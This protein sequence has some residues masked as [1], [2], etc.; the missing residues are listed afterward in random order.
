MKLSHGEIETFNQTYDHRSVMHY[1]ENSFSSD[2]GLKTIIPRQENKHE[3]PA[4]GYNNKISLGDSVT[5]N[6][7]YQC[8]KC[9]GAL[10]EPSGSFRSPINPNRSLVGVERCEWRIRAAEGERIELFIMSLSIYESPDCAVDY[11]EIRNGYHNTSTVLARYCGDVYS[12]NL[13]ASNYL[14]VAYVKASEKIT[15]SGFRADYKT[16]CGSNID[17]ERNAPFILESTNYPDAYP[18]NRRCIWYITAPK[19]HRI[20]MTINYFALEMS[21][22]CIND[23]LEIKDGKNKRAVLIGLYCGIKNS[24]Q[25]NS[26]LRKLSVVFA[27]NEIYQGNGFSATLTAL[28]MNS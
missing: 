4:I 14:L 17:I 7:L 15:Y 25:V 8:P 10:L 22:G 16:I 11:L 2:R 26:T 19:N 13:I 28:P 12:V 27:S 23:F 24:W 20:V 5:T 6:I 18:P 3:V 21:D 9:G 1:P